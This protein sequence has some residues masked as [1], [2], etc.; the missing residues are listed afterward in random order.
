[1]ELSDAQALALELMKKHGIDHWYFQFDNAKF[2]FGGCQHN[3]R[4]IRLS[5]NLVLLN[6][7]SVVKNV[8]LHEIA[9]ALVSP[10][11]GHNWVWREKALEIGCDGKRCY[12]REDV[13]MVKGKVEGTCPKCGY[14]YRRHRMPKTQRSCGKCSSVF[15]KERLLLYARN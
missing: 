13:N 3:I 11:Y 4:L 8:I 1:M 9:H 5:K 14:T 7:V 15:D 12:S 10:K 6:E 2:R